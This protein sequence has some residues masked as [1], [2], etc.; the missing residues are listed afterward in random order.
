MMF[1]DAAA[2]DISSLQTVILAWTHVGQALVGSI[3]A[4]AFVFAFLWKMTAVE[5]RSVLQA[6][7]WIQRIV[8]G[9]IGVEMASQLI[10]VLTSGVG[11]AH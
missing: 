3:G 2:P 11:S 8:V 4:L 5:P 10:A 9:T 1:L 7:Q 6:K